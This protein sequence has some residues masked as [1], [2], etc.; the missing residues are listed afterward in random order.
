MAS[1]FQDHG[2]DLRVVPRVAERVGVR[3][4]GVC[5]ARI[6]AT[7]SWAMGLSFTGEYAKL[8]YLDRERG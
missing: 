1:R 7:G 8:A 6:G 2:A 4:G 3:T 5:P